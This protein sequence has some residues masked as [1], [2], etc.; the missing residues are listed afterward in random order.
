MVYLLLDN[1]K[2]AFALVREKPT[3][4]TNYIE[5]E[6]EEEALQYLGKIWTGTEFIKPLT[7]EEQEKLNL[8]CELEYIKC[9]LELNNG[10]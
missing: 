2:L 8:K 4:D 1:K 5:I 10:I 9:L 6:T 7:E 3:K